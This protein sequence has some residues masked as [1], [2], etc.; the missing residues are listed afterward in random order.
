MAR[1]PAARQLSA[2]SYQIPRVTFAWLLVA[3]LSVLLPHVLRMPF[4]LLVMCSGA[5]VGRVLIYQGRIGQPGN[6]VKM[7]LV[8][9]MVGLLPVQYGRDIFS[10]DAMVGV[11]LV[12]IT[13][14]LL[15][16]YQKRDVLL[17][18]Y[19]CYFTVIAEFLYSQAILITIYMS[20]SVVL[21]TGAL[22]SLHQTQAAQKPLRT[23]KMSAIVLLQS[24]PLM[25]AF[26]ILFPRISPLWSVPLQAPQSSTGLSDN[27]APGDIGEL[28]RSADVAFRVLFRGEPPAYNELYWR[29]LTLDEFNGRQWRRGFVPQDTSQYLGPTPNTRQWYDDIQV[30]GLPTDYNVIMEPTYRNW[31]YTLQMPRFSDSNMILRRDYQVENVRPVSQRYT[32]DARSYLTYRA[33]ADPDYL[34]PRRTRGL[35]GPDGNDIAGNPRARVFASELR[36]QFPRDDTDPNAADHALIDAVLEHFRNEEFFYTLSPATLGDNPVDEFLFD[37]REGFCEHYASAFTFLMRAVNIPARVVTGYQGGEFNPYDGTLTVR[38]YDAHAW[39][40]VWLPG[41]GWLRID[42]TAAVAPERI[43]QGSDFTLQEEEEFL[44]DDSFALVNFRGSAFVND[45]RLRLEM[46]DYAWNRF[47]LN[48]DQDAQF[49]LFNRLFGNVTRTKIILTVVTFMGL[50]G[51]FI[52]F[53]VFRRPSIA[54]K[55]LATQQYLRFCAYLARLGFARKPGETPQHYLERVGD[56]NP[57]WREEMRGIT[58]AFVA[59]TFGGGADDKD[60]LRNLQRRVRN[61]RVLS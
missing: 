48:Y 54:P 56:A 29:A 28:T 17:V 15:E 22:M 34:P 27:M 7:A 20:C 19:L 53:V 24:A 11:L 59:I 45:L 57:Q 61:F 58:E 37:T 36:E 33:D 16:M 26:F 39:S 41:E 50:V 42:P 31:I 46:M 8:V 23:L 52:A 49:Q 47:V 25:L 21:I 12:S 13:L 4:W 40:E 5:I 14:K 51:A 1:R 55:P 44:N 18:M 30:A 10:T 3:L 43:E 2:D 35:V 6:K 9:T 60:Q 32:Y 38:Q